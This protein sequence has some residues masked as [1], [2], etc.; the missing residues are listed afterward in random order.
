MHTTRRTYGTVS[1]TTAPTLSRLKSDAHIRPATPP[2][3]SYGHSS[4]NS[5]GASAIGGCPSAG[6]QR[7]EGGGSGFCGGFRRIG[8]ILRRK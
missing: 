2:P 8:P 3:I 4:E 5:F 7:V 1:D 6:L